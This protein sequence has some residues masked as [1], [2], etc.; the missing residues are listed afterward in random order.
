MYDLARLD[1]IYLENVH[2]FVEGA[3]SHANRHNKNDTFCPCV[4]CKKNYV[5]GF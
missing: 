3:K 5:A 4:D 1:H 2:Q